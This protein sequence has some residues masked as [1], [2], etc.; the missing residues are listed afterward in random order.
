M[1][2]LETTV[3]A[4]GEETPGA[5]GTSEENLAPSGEST[6]DQPQQEGIG[7]DELGSEN[8]PPELQETRKN[9]LRGFHKKTQ[10]LR[11][12]E[13]R[14]EST[15]TDLKT[16]SQTLEQLMVQPWFKDAMA[17]ERAR[18]EG[19][20]GL[21][22]MDLSDDDLTAAL[23]NKDKKAF[24]RLVGRVAQQIADGRQ[25]PQ[26]ER[27]TRAEGALSELRSSQEFDAI[28]RKY[29]DF[30]ALSDSGAL[31]P[32]LEKGLDYETAYKVYK[33]D[34]D[35]PKLQAEMERKAEERAQE[36]LD[37]SR[38]GAISRG[39]APRIKGQEIIKARSLEDA[40][41]KTWDLMV[42]KGRKADSFTLQKE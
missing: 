37:T 36:L 30:G 11:D 16:K 1:P 22:D 25:A 19:R 9:L 6:S 31:E 24:I 27:L 40:F 42:R 39:G 32:Y 18:R 2:D 26:A 15:V 34:K 5:S 10:E 29:K 14:L 21:E 20:V 12:K 23:E 8:L 3:A 28:A 41:E 7:D 35:L 13:L 4:Q 38:A 17:K 33:A